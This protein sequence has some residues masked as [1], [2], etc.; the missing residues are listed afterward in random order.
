MADHN[1]LR[2]GVDACGKDCELLR[3]ELLCRP[4]RGGHS[5][6]GVFCGAADPRKMLQAGG[7][8]LI[9]QAAGHG[10]HKARNASGL[11]AV[12]TPLHDAALHICQIRYRRKVQIESQT[13]KS[14]SYGN[15]CLIRI[16][17]IPG[18]PDVSGAVH[19]RPYA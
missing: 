19:L 13:C 17:R 4:I 11:R 1:H 5:L 18:S 8:S 10:G 2:P 7:D 9:S 12:G 15:A 6:V 16:A 3:P 14:A